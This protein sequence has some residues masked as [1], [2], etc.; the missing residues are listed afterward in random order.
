[1]EETGGGSEFKTFRVKE[2]HP[3]FGAELEGV[4]FPNPSDEQFQEILAAMAKYG[5]CVFRKTGM[6]DTAHVEFSRRMGDLDDIRPYITAGRKM[7]YDYYELFDAGNVDEDGNVIDPNSP[8]AQYQKGNALFHVD[9]SFNPRRAS[10][11]LLR[12]Y[13]LPPPGHGGNTDFAD[14][15][16]AFDELPEA[17]KSELLD[18]DYVAAHCMAHSRKVAAPDFFKDL[19]V[20]TQ[21]MHLH[22][23]AQKHEPSGRMNL[24]V[25]AHA[26]HVEGLDP[27]QS[28]ALLKQLLD[29]TTQEKYRTSIAWEN[30]TDMIIWDNTCVLHRAGSGTFAGKFKRDLRRTTVHDASSTAWGLNDPNK[31]R[32]PGFS[33]GVS[34]QVPQPVAT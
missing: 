5:V 31:A 14:S 12:A 19:D 17:L 21:P 2:L 4:D 16:T 8:K 20:S 23:I 25:A 7:R 26:H 9:S 10:F 27:A 22:K 33:L 1:M 3:N 24:Y 18:K 15:R 11:S 6:D 29:H 32:R 30:P 13:E 34:N 28:D